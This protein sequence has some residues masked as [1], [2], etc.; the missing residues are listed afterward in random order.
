MQ[1]DTGGFGF[2]ALYLL[3]YLWEGAVW[4]LRMG[5]LGLSWIWGGVE[6][7]AV[8]AVLPVALEVGKASAFVAKAISSAV[9]GAI[10][11]VIQAV[12]GVSRVF[13]Q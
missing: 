9:S 5:S 3:G 2:G 12:S 10:S 4:V 13:R 7:F 8:V 1:S 11:A 6:W